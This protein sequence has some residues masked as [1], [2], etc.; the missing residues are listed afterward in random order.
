MK[1]SFHAPIVGLMIFLTFISAFPPLST[2]L[3]LPAMP[4]MG[5]QLN[6]DAAKVQWT[7]SGFMFSFALSMLLWGPLSDRYGRRP[8]LLCGSAL[9]VL[10]SVMAAISFNLE[11]LIVSRSL[12]GAGSAALSTT[13]MAI[14]KDRFAAHRM[15][16][17]LALM[18]TFIVLAPMLAP[19]VGAAMLLVTSWRGI[20]WVLAACGVLAF[21]GG[22][23]FKESLK[24]PL[25]GAWYHSLGRI[26]VVFQNK[27]FARL[28]LL[29]SAMAM[30]FMAYLAVSSYIFQDIFHLNAQTFGFFFAATAG[31]SMLGAIVY[32]KFLRHFSR[33]FLLLGVFV[34]VAL[35]GLCLIFFGK[36]NLW[37]FT[38]LTMTISFACS[39][40]R[41]PATVLMLSQLESD[42]GTVSALIGSFAFLFGALS[43][44]LCS[45]PWPNL[46]VAYGSISCILGVFASIV[47]I[48]LNQYQLFKH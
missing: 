24:K 22:L 41:A 16:K 8:I 4:H 25:N 14:V 17:M 23:F 40:S 7:L 32:I 29:F 27:G 45:L 44:F 38:F 37:L 28:L 42:S 15:E 31:V 19:I 11:M 30:P 43:M 34:S 2:D 13:A 5:E 35:A 9:F 47:W 20:F 3:Y 18:Q 33:Y 39:A 46:I 1:K 36:L 12:Q 48:I 26:V 6:A 21:V 10:A